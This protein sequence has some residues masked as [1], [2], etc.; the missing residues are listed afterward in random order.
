[1]EGILLEF[2]GPFT[3]WV[4]ALSLA[5]VLLRRHTIRKRHIVILVA[6][7]VIGFAAFFAVFIWGFTW[8]DPG[9]YASVYQGT[10]RIIA[11]IVVGCG[12]S[13]GFSFILKHLGL[14]KLEDR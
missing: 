5:L 4:L 11:G 1:M 10:L 2:L 7:T 3:S 12:S 6:I 9:R 13:V 14:A 8:R